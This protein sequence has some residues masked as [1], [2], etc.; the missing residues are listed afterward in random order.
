LV[1]AGFGIGYHA[2]EHFGDIIQPS[3]LAF[4]TA[5]VSLIS[6]EILFQITY[7]IGKRMGSE[8]L[9]KK[10]KIEK[11]RKKERKKCSLLFLISCKCLAS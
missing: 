3:Q 5:V 11:E 1:L 2:Y 8:L 10:K 7:R 6:K 9:S 4:W